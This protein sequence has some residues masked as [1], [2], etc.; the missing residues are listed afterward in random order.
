M[1]SP[2]DGDADEPVGR[3]LLPLRRSGRWHHIWTRHGGRMDMISILHKLQ[4]YAYRFFLYFLV[5]AVSITRY[6]LNLKQLG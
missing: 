1:S 5:A 2:L 3:P 4:E 6:L